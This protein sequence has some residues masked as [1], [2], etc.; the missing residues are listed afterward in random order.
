M[1]MTVPID[2][3]ALADIRPAFMGAPLT[4]RE[5]PL[6]GG[7]LQETLT[8]LNLFVQRGPNIHQRRLRLDKRSPR[9]SKLPLQL[10]RL[11]P[12]RLGLRL[13]LL[14]STGRRVQIPDSRSRGCLNLFPLSVGPDLPLFGRLQRC[15]EPQHSSLRPVSLLEHDR[16]TTVRLRR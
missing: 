9:L 12:S 7:G 11:Q 6:A 4:N 14:R 3:L 1:K 5:P 2:R 8:G 10:L 16:R 13:C 15:S